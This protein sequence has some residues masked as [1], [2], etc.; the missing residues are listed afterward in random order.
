MDEK[1]VNPADSGEKLGE[2]LA[3]GCC[4][5]FGGRKEEE[6]LKR[7]PRGTNSQRKLSSEGRERERERESGQNQCINYRRGAKMG[8][9]RARRTTLWQLTEH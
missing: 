3:L 7:G 4:G 6:S 2:D 1:L 9:A 8:A 5:C